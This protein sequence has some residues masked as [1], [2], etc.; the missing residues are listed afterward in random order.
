MRKET[1]DGEKRVEDESK[2]IG[3]SKQLENYTRTC[4][5]DNVKIRIVN[6]DRGK[7]SNV[8]CETLGSN[9]KMKT[10]I[11]GHGNAILVTLLWT[12]IVIAYE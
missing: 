2:R 12:C 8:C 7:Y 5:K 10:E 9:G 6:K 11:R 3:K 1:N 4:Y